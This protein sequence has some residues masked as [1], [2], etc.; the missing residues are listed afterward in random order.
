MTIFSASVVFLISWWLVFL[1][2]LSIG[3]RSQLEE[4]ERPDGTEA[5]APVRHM[6]PKKMVW[7]T[8]GAA[9]VTFIAFLVLNSGIIPPPDVPWNES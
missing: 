7:A 4:G 1:A 6:L 3:V 8:I 9:L 5:G 2:T